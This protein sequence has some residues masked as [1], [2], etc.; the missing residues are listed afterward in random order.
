MYNCSAQYSCETSTG[1]AG[2]QKAAVLAAKECCR[3]TG[4][5]GH[6]SVTGSRHG[7]GLSICMMPLLPIGGKGSGQTYRQT[8]QRPCASSRRRR[9]TRRTVLLRQWRCG[10]S[11]VGGP[12]RP[13]ATV[14]IVSSAVATFCRLTIGSA[15]AVGGLVVWRAGVATRTSYALA[16]VVARVNSGSHKR[17]SVHDYWRSPPAKH[18][19]PGESSRSRAVKS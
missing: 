16:G 11:V 3:K 10:A 13:T 1:T 9:L 5:N 15:L 2:E 17:A 6:P 12:R 8:R 18:P 4:D 19:R 14:L 7:D